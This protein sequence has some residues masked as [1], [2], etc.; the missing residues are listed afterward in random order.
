MKTLERFGLPALLILASLGISYFFGD[1]AT[2]RPLN[3]LESFAWQFLSLLIGLTGSFIFGRQSAREAAREI[4]K[5]S[6]RSAFRRLRSLYDSISRVAYTIEASQNSESLDDHRM[7]LAELKGIVFM[8]LTTADDALEDW[9][10]IIPEDVEE[11][12][13]RLSAD[14]ATEERQ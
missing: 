12:Y 4:I 9:R 11:L 3:S 8:Q 13:G 10:D 6:A 7:I 5:P 2:K 1:V 14:N